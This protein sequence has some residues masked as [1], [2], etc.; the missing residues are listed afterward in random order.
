[1]IAAGDAQWALRDN[2]VI[3]SLLKSLVLLLSGH[4]LLVP[5]DVTAARVALRAGAVA[6]GA[7][8]ILCPGAGLLGDL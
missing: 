4:I 2:A 7:A 6:G 3:A 8:A 1:M 5:A